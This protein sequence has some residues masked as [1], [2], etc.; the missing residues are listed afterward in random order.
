MLC[1]QSG[2]HCGKTILVI[3]RK[4]NS[5]SLLWSG[6]TFAIDLHT[7]KVDFAVVLLPRQSAVPLLHVRHQAPAHL[8]QLLL[9]LPLETQSHSGKPLHPHADGVGLCLGAEALTDKHTH[10]AC[11][12]CM[13]GVGTE[14]TGEKQEGF[15]LRHFFH[16]EAGVPILAFSSF[17]SCCREQRLDNSEIHPEP[18][19]VFVSD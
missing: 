13:R 15:P 10:M 6:S 17:L 14:E 2:F 1:S 4:K 11:C 7:V 9:L 12:G 5:L 19:K 16:P 3:L 8:R 18:R